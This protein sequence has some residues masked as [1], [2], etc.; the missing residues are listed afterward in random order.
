MKI[1]D[2]SGNWKFHSRGL[3]KEGGRRY[4]PAA[5]TFD[6]GFIK[7]IRAEGGYL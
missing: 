7:H 2:I 3:R 1:I 4:F 5:G 6:H